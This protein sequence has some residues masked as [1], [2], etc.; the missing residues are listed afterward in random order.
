MYSRYK[1]QQIL[2]FAQM[3]LRSQVK[4]IW[5]RETMNRL[6]AANYLPYVTRGGLDS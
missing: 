4:A 3:G 2:H 6:Q 5:L 1:R